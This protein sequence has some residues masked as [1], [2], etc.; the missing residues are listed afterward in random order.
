MPRTTDT[1]GTFSGPDL[2]SEQSTNNEEL[3]RM[4]RRAQRRNATPSQDLQTLMIFYRSNDGLGYTDVRLQYDVHANSG[5]EYVR[6]CGKHKT[7]MA[8]GVRF[9]KFGVNENWN[10]AD[11]NCQYL[12]VAK[13]TPDEKE[14]WCTK[15]GRIDRDDVTILIDSGRAVRLCCTAGLRLTLEF[16]FTPEEFDDDDILDDLDDE[17]DEDD[18]DDNE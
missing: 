4:A 6:N 5:P 10:A 15:P 7:N 12:W 9:A 18:D 16:P 3:M 8:N 2:R 17:A 11:G 14:R 13:V 1:E